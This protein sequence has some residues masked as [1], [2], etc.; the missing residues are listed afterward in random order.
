[1][2]VRTLTRRFRDEVGQS[3]QQWVVQRRVDRARQLL[4]S[5]GLSIGEVAREAGFGDPLLLRRH[6]RTHVGLTP[7]AY[8]QAYSATSPGVGEPVHE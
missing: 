4:E 5:T 7:N 2:S 6:L 8:R 3:P 1:M